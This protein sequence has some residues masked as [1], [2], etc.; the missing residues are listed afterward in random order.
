MSKYL[1]INCLICFLNQIRGLCFLLLRIRLL[2]GCRSIFGGH[3]GYLGGFLE[4]TWRCVED[5]SFFGG[6]GRK[7]VLSKVKHT[8]P[9]VIRTNIGTR[10]TRM[11]LY[12]CSCFQHVFHAF[13]MLFQC[14][15]ILEF[16]P[17]RFFLTAEGG[18]CSMLYFPTGCVVPFTGL[19]KGRWH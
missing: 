4:G 8:R 7:H 10:D 3:F 16:L 17:P 6:R 19:C 2:W 9:T 15:W 12:V 11:L 14:V 13:R 18:V 5:V 1:Q